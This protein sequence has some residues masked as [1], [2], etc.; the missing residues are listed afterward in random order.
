MPH[1]FNLRLAL[2]IVA[3]F[4]LL[5]F[6]VLHRIIFTT[7]THSAGYDFYHFHWNMTWI[8]HALSTPTASIYETNYV[9]APHTVNLSYHTLA[10]FWYP[11][12]ALIEP[13]IGTLSAVNLILYLSC[14]LNGVVAYAFLRSENA[15]VGLALLGAAAFQTL[16]TLRYFLFN[17]HL[18]L[19]P[20]FW[21]PIH[22]LVWRSV[23]EA[24]SVRRAVGLAL[25]QGVL[26]FGMVI[27][28]LQ[29]P[30]FLAFVIVPYTLWKLASD[31][32]QIPR[33]IG[34]GLIAAV[35]ALALLWWI[36]LIPALLRFSGTL[37]PGIVE[38]RPG[39]ALPDGYLSVLE[40][41]W[42][43]NTPSIGVFLPAVLL[44]SAGII[45][46]R[47]V[48]RQPLPRDSWLW[49]A[50]ASAALLITVG[51]DTFAYRAVFNLTRGMFGMPWRFAPV[52][53]LGAVVLIGKLWRVMQYTVL[54]LFITLFATARIFMQAPL[55]PLPRPLALYEQIADDP[56]AS[57]V[58]EVPTALATGE[59]IIGD[60]R[61]AALQYYGTVHGKRMINAFV[62]RAPIEQF[63]PY[64]TD[65]PLISWLGQRRPYDPVLVEAELRRIIPEWPVGYIVVH[66]E[67]IG[68]Y[69]T[70][71]EEILSVLNALPDLLCVITVE[72]DTVL[73]R[74]RRAPDDCPPPPDLQTY[75]ID[76]GMSG[77]ESAIGT[78]WY[79]HEEVPGTRVRWAGVGSEAIL[80]AN[81]PDGSY[82]MTIRAQ[83][84]R[85]ARSVRVL[86]GDESIG[87][88]DLPPDALIDRE[89]TIP[90]RL[91]ASGRPTAIR[92]MYGESGLN[93]DGRTLAIMV[94]W[95]RFDRV[96]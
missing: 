66:Q 37:A 80:Y 67:M 44:I 81:V 69:G 54:I 34:L 64:R 11:L 26:L 19:I 1:R 60:P 32:R 20:W 72:R 42:N 48:R 56:E 5:A 75:M 70:T 24:T 78:G 58:I 12:W 45:I 40:G 8:R 65:D 88:F 29:F 73:Y 85:S 79:P 92:L 96:P 55:E 2:A 15:P 25:L 27:S 46:L 91:V 94:D 83:A 57:V 14:V 16:P 43:W 6:I 90:A 93:T 35:T 50:I 82:K 52:F 61:A 68:R 30:I 18:N 77:D 74:A 36:G 59:T 38:N 39:I 4:G 63:W 47:I 10:V 76:L 3:F 9:F 21:I 62:A 71:N 17:T 33:I 41:W 28:D 84:F 23:I 13:S 87:T 7:G 31:I 89:L 51:P 95:V 49:L 53:A 86:I 22:L